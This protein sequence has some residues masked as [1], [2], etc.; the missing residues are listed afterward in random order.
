MPSWSQNALT[1]S[2]L[3]VRRTNLVPLDLGRGA[4][5]PGPRLSCEACRP[6]G[7][8]RCHCWI[9]P[10]AFGF[11]FSL[12]HTLCICIH[13]SRCLKVFL[14]S[15]FESC[16]DEVL[17]ALGALRVSHM[18]DASPMHQFCVVTHK[19]R[20]SGCKPPPSSVV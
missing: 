3:L 11:L 5:P 14:A 1:K 19:M 20:F 7:L 10:D 17:P 8:A 6:R 4:R 2:W 9:D 18:A 16:Q 13:K 15:C 12:L